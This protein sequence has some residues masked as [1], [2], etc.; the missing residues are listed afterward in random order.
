M[1][2][3]QLRKQWPLSPLPHGSYLSISLATQ[4]RFKSLAYRQMLMQ[5]FILTVYR[6]LN[7]PL[8][9]IHIE[10][11][12]ISVCS[13]YIMT[14]F[15]YWNT[16]VSF[17]VPI[18]WGH[19]LKTK[20]SGCVHNFTTQSWSSV[21]LQYLEWCYTI[22]I[23]SSWTMNLPPISALCSAPLLTAT[24]PGGG[25]LPQRGRSR[26]PVGYAGRHRCR[27]QGRAQCWCRGTPHGAGPAASQGHLG[28][29]RP[30]LHCLSPPSAAASAGARAWGTLR[31]GYLHTCHT[32][33]GTA[34][35]GGLP[36]T[37][38]TWYTWVTITH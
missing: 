11:L 4:N 13:T 8:N 12:S 24:Y 31:Y 19:T 14:L 20:P 6:T 1:I 34:G 7:F 27:S 38:L 37:H 10:S 15:L 30:A 2:I 26:C 9:C 25:G 16:S 36:A 22:L 32:L 23:S 3:G 35:R 33:Q 17:L 18:S 21:L 29:A 5:V 28:A